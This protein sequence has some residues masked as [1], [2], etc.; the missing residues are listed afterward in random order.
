MTTS[1][2]EALLREAH[3]LVEGQERL[4]RAFNTLEQSALEVRAQR[5][6]LLASLRKTLSA[7][8]EL[9][10]HGIGCPDC[11]GDHEE[12]GEDCPMLKAAERAIARVESYCR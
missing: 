3:D 12:T 7:A 4:A 11:P 2:R 5:D 9:H 8:V 6:D 10:A 1:M